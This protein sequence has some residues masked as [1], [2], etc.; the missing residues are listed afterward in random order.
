[1]SNTKTMNQKT[2]MEA[3]IKDIKE[4]HTFTTLLPSINK[5]VTFKCRS[6][7]IKIQVTGPA[8]QS[9]IRSELEKDFFAEYSCTEDV[10]IFLC[11]PIFNSVLKKAIRGEE[12]KFTTDGESLTFYFGSRLSFNIKLMTLTDESELEIPDLEYDVSTML[13]PHVLKEW[14]SH[15][16]DMTKGDVTFS[17]NTKE[18]DTME[19]DDDIMVLTSQ[20]ELLSVKKDEK[21][22]FNI[23]KD[24]V[25]PVTLGNPNMKTITSLS[26]FNKDIC[27]CFNAEYPIEFSFELN[28]HATVTCWF[29]QCLMDEDF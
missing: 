13:N 18:P 6:D 20:G 9:Y 26:Q 1:M 3:T 29:A 7:K 16:V 10:D 23:K 21:L 25:K 24:N 12:V 8:M 17:F 15:I 27:M 22:V 5:E 14:N 11:M 2:I 28:E 4:F 19:T